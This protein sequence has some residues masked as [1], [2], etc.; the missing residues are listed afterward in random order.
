MT[1]A[2]CIRKAQWNKAQKL[3]FW[4]NAGNVNGINQELEDMKNLDFQSV[5]N[6]A[7]K[8]LTIETVSVLNYSPKSQE[9]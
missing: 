1:W 6:Q 3:A 2:T 5:I 7:K 4:E 9:A 8:T